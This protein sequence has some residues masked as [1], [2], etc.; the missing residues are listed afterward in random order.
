MLLAAAAMLIPVSV[1]ADY[2]ISG[3]GISYYHAGSDG[4]AKIG[5]DTNWKSVFLGD[6]GIGVTDNDPTSR[7]HNGKQVVNVVT[8]PSRQVA[9]TEIGSTAV[10]AGLSGALRD[11]F[12]YNENYWPVDGPWETGLPAGW[13]G[14]NSTQYYGED[15]RTSNAAGYYAYGT[16][17]NLYEAG[18]YYLA[19]KLITDNALIGVMLDGMYLDFSYTGPSENAGIAYG[20][21]ANFLVGTSMYLDPGQHSLMFI[22]SNYA[23]SGNLGNPTGLLAQTL[24]LTETP[25]NATPEPASML[26]FGIGLAGAVLARRRFR[27]VSK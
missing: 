17:F 10:V 3:T 4:M 2:Y 22:V 26:I 18:D 16:D 8:D 11:T 12:V 20:D 25:P 9:L 6:F 13:V 5:F 19:G 7:T 23:A 1:H 15:G 21:T 27:K 14:H 24:M